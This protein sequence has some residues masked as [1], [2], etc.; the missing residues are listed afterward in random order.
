MLLGDLLL[1]MRIKYIVV[2]IKLVMKMKSFV[3][4]ILLEMVL[5]YLSLIVFLIFV[6]L[7]FVLDCDMVCVVVKVVCFVKGRV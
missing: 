2:I 6:E 5:L 1:I 7:N 3:V 4:S